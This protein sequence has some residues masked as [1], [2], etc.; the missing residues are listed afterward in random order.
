MEEE[1]IK[2]PMH[3]L[4][5]VKEEPRELQQ[6]PTEVIPLT[7]KVKKQKKPLNDEQKVAYNAKQN[8]RYAAMTDEQKAAHNTK[9]KQKYASLT[10]EQKAE[11]LQKQKEAKKPLTDEQKIKH[12]QKQ[13]DRRAKMTPEQRNQQTPEQRARK[14]ERAKQ[15]YDHRMATKPCTPNQVFLCGKEECMMCRERSFADHPKAQYWSTKNEYKPIQIP[16]GS[17]KL[18][19]FDCPCGHEFTSPASIV[20]MQK[21]WCKYCCDQVQSF[22]ENLE[23]KSCHERS[24]ASSHRIGNWDPKNT[25]NPRFIS[26]RGSKSKYHFICD[27]GHQFKMTTISVHI[28]KWCPHCINKTEIKLFDVLQK[29]WPDIQHQPRFDWCVNSKS[30]HRLPFDFVIDE[31]KIIIELD[32]P[33]HFQQISNWAL[34]KEVRRRDWLKMNAAIKNG[35]TVIRLLQDDVWRDKNNWHD[36]LFAN[37]HPYQEPQ[38]VYVSETNA[39]S[40]FQNMFDDIPDN[41]DE[42]LDDNE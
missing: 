41:N 4:E 42:I 31:L 22:C 6:Q 16:L 8:Q 3:P 30:N 19:T 5:G 1:T 34:L 20:G 32:G 9:Q 37:I 25:A 14:N 40:D 33:Q 28:G 15:R 38:I 39:Y 35:Y 23:C 7:K 18:I 26:K 17:R 24:F 11:R 36:K 10:P 27:N 12:N 29:Q 13:Q 21:S 2:M